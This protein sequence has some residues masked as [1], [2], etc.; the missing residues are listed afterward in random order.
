M[1]LVELFCRRVSHDSVL[2]Q[3]IVMVIC[4]DCLSFGVCINSE[5]VASMMDGVVVNP[6][7]LAWLTEKSLVVKLG[8]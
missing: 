2:P 1:E 7:L 3:P 4:P 5:D 6:S 8:A